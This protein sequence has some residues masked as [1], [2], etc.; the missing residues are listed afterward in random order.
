MKNQLRMPAL[1]AICAG[2]SIAAWAQAPA[3]LKLDKASATKIVQMLEESGAGYAKAAD[4]VWVAKFIGKQKAEIVVMVIGHENMLILSGVI[5]EKKEFKVSPD[6]MMQLLRLNDQYDRVKVGIDGDGDL[7]VRI[8][9]SIRVVDAREF[10]ENLDQAS[11][12]A[13]EIYGAIKAHL[14][15]AK[16]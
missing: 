7:F 5:A 2:L 6:L 11:A 9:L 13:D 4:N 12:A 3:P 16:K 1:L 10:K 8:D 14:L 15:P